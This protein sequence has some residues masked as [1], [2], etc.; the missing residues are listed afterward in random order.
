M[1]PNL[2]IAKAVQTACI[3]AAIRAY[4][5]AGLSGLCHEGR[6]ECAIDAIRSVALRPLID[7]S[8]NEVPD[9]S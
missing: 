6:W 4:E 7:I 1:E 2:R 8:T 9:C 3:E 5:D